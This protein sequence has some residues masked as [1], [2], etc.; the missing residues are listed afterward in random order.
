M[1]AVEHIEEIAEFPAPRPQ[2]EKHSAF[3]AIQAAMQARFDH[4]LLVE[5]G[6]PDAIKF[7]L[8][9][10]SRDI[11]YW[12]EHYAWTYDPRNPL[13]NPPLPAWIPF[14]LFP[15][16]IEL[17]KWFDYL[18]SLRQDGCLKKSRDV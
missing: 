14:N 3:D 7:E 2:P 5:G 9:L 10:C 4:L 13:E 15:K 1:S 18:Q 12:F 6:G 8:E 16:Q 11:F 17:V